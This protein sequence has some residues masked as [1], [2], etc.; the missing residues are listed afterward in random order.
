[1]LTDFILNT[2]SESRVENMAM[3]RIFDVFCAINIA[4]SSISY[5]QYTHIY[6]F[7]P[8]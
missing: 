1:M 6:I 8:A 5:K 4:E 3:V 2:V 7:G